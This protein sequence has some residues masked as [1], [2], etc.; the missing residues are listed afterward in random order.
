MEKQI[1]CGFCPVHTNW[2]LQSLNANNIISRLLETDSTRFIR[3]RINK[4][5][6]GIIFKVRPYQVV[7]YLYK[8]PI[9]GTLTLTMSRT[10]IL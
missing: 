7:N 10:G 2:R 8:A 4:C 6:K 5:C 3:T 1:V 9:N